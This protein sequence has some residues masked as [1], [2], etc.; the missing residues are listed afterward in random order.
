MVSFLTIAIWCCFAYSL[1]EGAIDSNALNASIRDNEDDAY[2]PHPNWSDPFDWMFLKAFADSKYKN[3]ILSPIS[4]KIVLAL[5]YEGSSGST[6]KEFQNI[7]LFPE[8]K[9]IVRENFYRIIQA[10]K[11]QEKENVL[12]LGTKIFMDIGITP[13]QSFSAVAMHNYHTSIENLDFANGTASSAAIN[14]W[15]EKLTEGKIPS[16][17]SP[18]EVKDA[19]MLMINTIFFKGAWRHEFP[20]N[21]TQIGG[22]YISPLDVVNVPLMRTTDKFFYYES[23]ALDAKI[24]RL[25]YKGKKYSM[26][27]ILP[28]TKAG[29]KTLLKKI[30]LDTLKRDFYYMD[31]VPVEVTL[32]KLK[33]DFKAKITNMLEEFG[34][35]QMFQNT[36]SFPGIARGEKNTLRMLYVTD[37]IQKSGIQMDEEGS[38]VYSSTDVQLTN[39]FGEVDNFFNATHPFMFFIEEPTTGTILFIGKVENPLHIDTVTMRNGGLSPEMPT[40]VPAST[41]PL[42]TDRLNLEPEIAGSNSIIN[43]FNYFDLELLQEFSEA[44]ENV[45]ISPASIKTTLSMILEGAKGKCAQEIGNALRIENI[46]DS[47]TRKQ[48]EK[49]LFDLN[50]KT[51]SNELTTANAIF[52]SNKLKLLNEYQEKLEKHYSATIKPLDFSNPSKAVDEINAWV[53]NATKGNIPTIIDDNLFDESTLVITNALYFKGIWQTTFNP[54]ETEIKCFEVPDLGC[55]QVPIM[56]KTDTLNYN[57][58]PY[59]NAHAVEVPYKDN[60]YSMLLL[61]PSKGTN[62]KTL[63]RDLQHSHFDNILDSLRPTEIILEMPRFEIENQLSLVDYL[64]PLKIQEIFGPNANLSGIVEKT[65]I[66]IGNIVHKAK[67][68]VDEQGTKATAATAAVVIPLMGDTALRVSANV[69]FIFFIYRKESKNILFEGILLDPKISETTPAPAPDVVKSTPRTRHIPKFQNRQI[70]LAQPRRIFP[71][72]P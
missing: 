39:K 27:I 25:P 22:F 2:Y 34:L 31:Y 15:V 67:I 37:I 17:V 19:V 33:F 9:Q 69:P 43:R 24:L 57:L 20:K 60:K 40:K 56:Q 16:L 5:L 71:T 3:V 28:N 52:V 61:I 7:L 70:N 12:N 49:L 21:R 47:E 45:F 41:I 26:F 65:N 66:R 8:K 35:R 62:I 53:S 51:A 54:K 42:S 36:A 38:T 72:Y 63:A 18:D 64:K 58:V 1:V 44:N 10:L 55:K 11:T 4:L 48:L 68:E 32:P 23:S 59:L 29:L 14:S 30:D 50:E 13:E 6:A 46:D